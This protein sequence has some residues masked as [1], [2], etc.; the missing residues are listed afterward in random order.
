MFVSNWMSKKKILTVAPEDSISEATRIINDFKVKHIPVMKEEKLV[1]IISDR[2]I[3][4]FL[5][6]KATSLD[7]YELNYLLQDTK[8]KSV[9][10]KKVH[11]ASP[12]TPIEEASMLLMDN[13]IGCLPVLSEHKLV[14]IISDQDIYRALVDITGVRHGGIRISV[15]ISD[16][17]GS[18]AAVADIV[19]SR[20]YRLQ[21]IMTSYESVPR[22][23][24]ALVIRTKGKGDFKSLSKEIKTLYKN[25][26]ITKG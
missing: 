18:I 24:R 10:K 6:S 1:G 3:K 26:I 22:D 17:T 2:D 11:T 8:V 25:A 15:I 12:E 13:Q 23:K 16:R 14:G 7:I 20:G 9:M 5:P 4:E 21:S 19:R